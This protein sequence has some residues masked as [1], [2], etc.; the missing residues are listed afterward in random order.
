VVVSSG[1]EAHLSHGGDND[2]DAENVRTGLCA[3]RLMA[4]DIVH[5]LYMAGRDGFLD[6]LVEC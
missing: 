6:F 2:D 5:V 1:D 4:R 3:I